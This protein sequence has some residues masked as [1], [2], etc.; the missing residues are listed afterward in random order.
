MMRKIVSVFFCVTIMLINLSG[1]KKSKDLPENQI[2]KYNLV[3]EPRTLDPQACNDSAANTVIMNIFEGLVRLDENDNV[4]PGVAFSWEISENNLEYTFYLRENAFWSDKEKTP[5]TADDFVFGFQRAIDR[6][7]KSAKAYTLYCIKNARDI[8]I[9]GKDITSLGVRAVDS[10]TLKIEL[11]Y[12]MENFLSLLATPLAMPCNRDFF[13]KTNGQYGLESTTILCN[14]AFKVKTRYGWDHYNALNL[15]SNENYSGHNV[16]VPAGV[17][18]TIGK[19]V[20]DATNLIANGTVDAALLSSEEQIVAA[21]NKKFPVVSFKDTIWGLAFNTQDTLFSNCNVRLGFLKA[22]NRNHIL[23]HVPENYEIVNDIIIDGLVVNE[24]NYRDVSERNLYLK[25]DANAKDF[26][27]AGIKELNLKT[28]PK[29]TILCLDTAAMKAIVSNMIEI[30]NEKLEYYFNMEP[31]SENVLKS[32]VAASN[33]QIALL[34]IFTES[35]FAL[36]FLNIFKS[37]SNKNVTNLN[38]QEYDNFIN[39]AFSKTPKDSIKYL[40]SAEKFLNDNAIFYPMLVQDRFFA[41]SNK[42]S[43]LIFHNYNQ[44]IDFMLATKVK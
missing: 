8:N 5:V 4:I 29:V 23:S 44:G 9:N 7:T 27:N 11:E 6:Y 38:S 20:T 37:D 10:H 41:C 34:P 31:V 18:F 3:S 36:D 40:F 39:G 15:V 32:R 24:Q 30:L 12:P 1:C 26:L 16:P 33:Y 14:G 19:D 22:L 17:S 35:K 13:E 25:E 43:K 28:L 42:V 2:I 21:K